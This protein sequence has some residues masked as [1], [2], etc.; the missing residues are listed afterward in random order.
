MVSKLSSPLKNTIIGVWQLAAELI[1]LQ[2]GFCGACGLSATSVPGER[3]FAFATLGWRVQLSFKFSHRLFYFI[4]L[5]LF[6]FPVYC[7]FFFY[8][9]RTTGLRYQLTKPR[10]VPLLTVAWTT[11]LRCVPSCV[12]VFGVQYLPCRHTQCEMARFPSLATL[13]NSFF[14]FFWSFFKRLPSLAQVPT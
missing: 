9:R 4:L 8:F 12:A 5:F 10:L 1:L 2:T 11:L 13:S 14:F 6:S 3:V 7:F